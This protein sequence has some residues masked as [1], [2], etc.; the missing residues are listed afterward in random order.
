MHSLFFK[1]LGA[2]LDQSAPNELESLLVKSLNEVAALSE[3]MKRQYC[4]EKAEDP[5]IAML[6]RVPELKLEERHQDNTTNNL[7]QLTRSRT[8]Y[9]SKTCMPI[10]PYEEINYDSESEIR[11]GQN[12]TSAGHCQ[13]M[14]EDVITKIHNEDE[15][16]LAIWN[17]FIAKN[18]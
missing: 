3:N 15:K 1:I 5:M 7:P 4:F 11:L 17:S 6:N 10:P 12:L 18:K 14:N 2:A 9:H 16:I 8:Y 13:D